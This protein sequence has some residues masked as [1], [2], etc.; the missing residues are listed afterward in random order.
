MLGVPV[1]STRTRASRLGLVVLSLSAIAGCNSIKADDLVG[2]WTMTESSR[3]FLPVQ[4]RT[5]APK[6]TLNSDG[7]FSAVDFP[8]GRQAKSTFAAAL[9]ARGV[10]TVAPVNGSDR[11]QLRF[12]DDDSGQQLFISDWASDGPGSPIKLYYFDGDP[13][14]GRRI[15]F[16]R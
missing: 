2:T 4:L 13:D 14:S 9:S 5:A 8:G 15:V 3:A 6:L 11:V 7:T 10:W 1:T 12:Q 16:V